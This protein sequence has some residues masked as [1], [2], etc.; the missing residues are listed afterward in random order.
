MNATFTKERGLTNGIIDIMARE[1]DE[2]DIAEM[3]R[4]VDT[5]VEEYGYEEISGEGDYNVVLGSNETVAQM[6]KDYAAAKKAA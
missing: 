5:L 1:D 6:K 3:E 4:V 2:K